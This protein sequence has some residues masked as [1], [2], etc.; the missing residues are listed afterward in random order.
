MG[1]FSRGT[2]LGVGSITQECCTMMKHVS[3]T[4]PLSSDHSPNP[5][6]MIICIHKSL[7]VVIPGNNYNWLKYFGVQNPIKHELDTRFKSIRNQGHLLRSDGGEK[8]AELLFL[9]N[10]TIASNIPVTLDELPCQR[11]CTDLR[12]QTTG[13]TFC[14]VN[15]I[16]SITEYRK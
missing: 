14:K 12:I 7:S 15:G 11:Q 8:T 9:Q 4:S 10:T 1:F 3:P 13:I 2:D 5:T 16:E 6:L